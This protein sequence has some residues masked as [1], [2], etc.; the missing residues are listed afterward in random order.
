MRRDER[1]GEKEAKVRDNRLSPDCSSTATTTLPFTS[2][3]R[4]EFVDASDIRSELRNL[5]IFFPPFPVERE[6]EMGEGDF[7]LFSC[8]F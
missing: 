4:T 7:S 2:Y 3:E 5:P 6:E 1:T 8:L